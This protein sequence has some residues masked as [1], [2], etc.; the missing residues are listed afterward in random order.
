MTGLWQKLNR[1][2]KDKN[3]LIDRE[4]YVYVCDFIDIWV[5]YQL[6]LKDLITQ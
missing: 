2:Y 4:L 5:F 1:E 6:K 3:S